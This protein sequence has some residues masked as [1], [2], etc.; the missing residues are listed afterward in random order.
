MLDQNDRI[1]MVVR[2]HRRLLSLSL[3]L[4]LIIVYKNFSFRI[5]I[6]NAIEMN[7]EELM[8]LKKPLDG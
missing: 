5:Q 4:L 6:K 3:S 8:S 1:R 2:A 7:E